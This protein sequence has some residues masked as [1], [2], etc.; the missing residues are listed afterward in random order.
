MSA[1][2]EF[3]LDSPVEPFVCIH[4]RIVASQALQHAAYTE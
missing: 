1:K 3:D 2:A 4:A